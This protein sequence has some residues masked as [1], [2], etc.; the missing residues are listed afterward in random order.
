MDSKALKRVKDR[1][2]FYEQGNI[3]LIWRKLKVSVNLLNFY[4]QLFLI[5]LL[6]MCGYYIYRE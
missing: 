6:E 4:I 1:V 5:I 3:N 2:Y